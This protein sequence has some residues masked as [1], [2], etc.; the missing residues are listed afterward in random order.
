MKYCGVYTITNRRT[1]RVY[2]G[3]SVDVVKRLR[4]HRYALRT[5]THKNS[6]LQHSFTKYGEDTFD[7]EVLE[8]V[9]SEFLRSTEQFWVNMCAACNPKHG[10]NIM[11]NTALVAGTRRSKT[12]KSRISQGMRRFHGE[13]A[14]KRSATRRLSNYIDGVVAYV[15]RRENES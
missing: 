4:D 15:S 7:F 2:I 13:Q 5:G 12:T 1:G 9:P 3:S 14:H 8:V 10:Y 11:P 6:R